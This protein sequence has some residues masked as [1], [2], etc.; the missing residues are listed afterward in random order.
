MSVCLSVCL[1]LHVSKTT[2]PNYMKFSEHVI[3]GRG[4]VLLRQQW[5]ML[6]TAGFVDDVTFSCNRP[7]GTWH[8]QYQREDRSGYQAV[9]NFQHIPQ[10]AP[11]YS[12]LLSYTMSAKC[13]PGHLVIKTCHTLPVDDGLQCVA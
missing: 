12:T 2:H 10:M 8:W 11:Q 6:S 1:C 5:R 9:I 7:Y 4:S 3:H 13:R